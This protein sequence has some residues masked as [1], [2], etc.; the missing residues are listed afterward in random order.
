MKTK[1]IELYEY[2]ELEPKA[3]E[4]A[5]R[6]WNAGNFDDYELMV[7]LDNRIAELLEIEKITPAEDTKHPKIQYSLGHSQGDGLMFT[8]VFDWRKYR[9]YITH[10]KGR[11]FHSNSAFIEVQELKNLG[12]HMDDEHASVKKFDAIYK[13][14][15]KELER[16]GY[17]YIDDM[18]SEA[19]FIEACNANE[20]TFRKDGTMENE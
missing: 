10:D 11:Y 18:Q 8:G 17:D 2:A 15:C 13:R 9:V 12:F 19:Y 3:K 20:Y 6:E 1:T 7:A 5:L 16:F 14:I 4:K